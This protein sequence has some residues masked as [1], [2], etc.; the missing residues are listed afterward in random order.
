MIIKLLQMK[1]T[2]KAS[3]YN[4]NTNYHSENASTAG[5]YPIL[6]RTSGIIMKILFI[7]FNLQSKPYFKAIKPTVLMNNNLQKTYIES[8]PIS[9]LC[10]D[11]QEINNLNQKSRS[12]YAMLQLKKGSYRRSRNAHN[13]IFI[14]I[15][16][17]KINKTFLNNLTS[18]CE[19]LIKSIISE[20]NNSLPRFVYEQPI[21]KRA[22][23][24]IGRE[25]IYMNKRLYPR[26][27]NHSKRHGHT[28]SI[29]RSS[30]IFGTPSFIS[31]T[32]N[33]MLDETRQY[34][35]KLPKSILD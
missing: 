31:G 12:Y 28:K 29:S 17:K 9:R 20:I 21:P 5:K 34:D 4:S 10:F 23:E 6:F 32:P 24:L 33:S 18:S 2:S 30:M 25:D 13:V 27:K 8:F 26:V 1:K 19:R 16:H 11:K 22:Y 7:Y 15:I 35:S 14:Y 3:N